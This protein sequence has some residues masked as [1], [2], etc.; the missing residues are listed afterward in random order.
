MW[1]PKVLL[2]RKCIGSCLPYSTFSINAEYNNH[3]Y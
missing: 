3:D 1:K 2:H